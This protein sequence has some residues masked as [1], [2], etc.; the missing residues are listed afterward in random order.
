MKRTSI[1]KSDEEAPNGE[2]DSI[3]HLMPP[4]ILGVVID[5]CKHGQVYALKA[6]SSHLHKHVRDLVDM[7]DPEPSYTWKKIFDVSFQ[8]FEMGAMD[9]F[10]WMLPDGVFSRDKD[11]IM[12]IITVEPTLYCFIMQNKVGGYPYPCESFYDLPSNH[13]I[14]ADA[15]EATYL[16]TEWRKKEPNEESD[17]LVNGKVDN[18]GSVK[19][20]GGISSLRKAT[21]SWGR[22]IRDYISKV[23]VSDRFFYHYCDVH[24]DH[25]KVINPIN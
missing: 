9:L 14:T 8:V 24:S 18:W 16:V 23:F 19:T 17:G 4:D 7:K 3:L 22:G 20:R 13:E 2:R 21:R 25:V 1:T 15:W 12:G 6:T 10:L 5:A 11:R